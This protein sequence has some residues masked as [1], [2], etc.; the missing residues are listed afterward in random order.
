MLSH[1]KGRLAHRF[2][3]LTATI[4]VL[5]TFGTLAAAQEQPVVVLQLPR[6][7]AGAPQ[8]VRERPGIYAPY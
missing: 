7:G 8:D 5:C 1:L 4:A 3:M 2:A 6:V